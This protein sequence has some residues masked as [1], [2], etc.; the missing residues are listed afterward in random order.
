MMYRPAP[1]ENGSARCIPELLL[2][3]RFESGPCSDLEG[4]E[5]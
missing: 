2:K 3:P 1:G 5:R 4:R